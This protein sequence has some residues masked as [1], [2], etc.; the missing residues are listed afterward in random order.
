MSRIYYFL[1]S[2]N[3]IIGVTCPAG[4]LPSF[5]ADPEFTSLSHANLGA[6]GERFGPCI[7]KDS[8]SFEYSG[9]CSDVGVKVKK[10]RYN[11]S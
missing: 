1:T 5:P 11:R 7:G 10:N 9:D 8:N 3:E 6:N 2:L 4:D